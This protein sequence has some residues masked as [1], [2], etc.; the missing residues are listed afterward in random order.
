MSA[1][2]RPADGGTQRKARGEVLLVGSK[3]PATGDFSVGPASARQVDPAVLTSS[4]TSFTNENAASPAPHASA[5]L[6]DVQDLNLFIATPQG[7]ARFASDITFAIS[8]GECV[9]LVGESGSGKTLTGLSILGLLP[10]GAIRATGQIRFGDVDLL[11]CPERTMRRIRGRQISMIFQEAMSA[12][13]PVFTVGQQISETIQA[14]FRCSKREA[15]ARAVEALAAVGVPSP[16]R[17]YEAYPHQLSGGLRQR[18]MIAIALVCE[19]ALLIADEPTT[20]LDVTVQAQI[21]D[22]LLARSRELGTALLLITH[23]LGVVASSCSRMVTMYAGQVVESGPVRQTLRR[24]LNP[25]TSGLLRSLPRLSPRKAPL[26]VI[27][28]RVPAVMAMPVGCRFAPRCPHEGADCSQ[29]QALATAGESS[30]R[31]CRHAQL[32]LPGIGG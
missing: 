27:K 20:A 10:R 22:L 19:P 13:D 6:L 26:P 5:P 31:C 15:K 32:D 4:P 23:D 7:D 1:R 21:M 28:G 16:E 24:P 8:P 25:Y 3:P 2:R 30:V 17:R 12:L 18:V 14:H 29:P 9:G 11:S